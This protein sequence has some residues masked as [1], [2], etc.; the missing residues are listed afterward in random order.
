MIRAVAASPALFALSLVVF[1]PLAGCDADTSAWTSSQAAAQNPSAA[2]A[3]YVAPPKVTWANRADDGVVLTG[4]AR[5]GARVRLGPPAG[6]PLFAVADRSGAWTLKLAPSDIVRL[7]GLSMTVGDRA[8]QAEGYLMVLPDGRVVQLRAGA[9]AWTLSSPTTAP[10]LLAVDH[11]DEG[12]AVIS[13]VAPAG[14]AVQAR[15]DRSRVVSGR[16]R[17]DGHFDLALSEPLAPGAHDIEL[18]GDGGRD[19]LSAPISPAEPLGAPFRET[20]TPYGWRVDWMTPGGG[21]QST[22]VFARPGAGA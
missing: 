15:I 11:D 2:E 20:R 1:A 5:A 7:Y 9:G 4:A 6:E 14:G 17:A 10:R 13:G 12:G 19:A 16:A 8:V 18:V 3:G 21:V 22:L